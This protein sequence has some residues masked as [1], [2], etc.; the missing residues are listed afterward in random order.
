[1]QII[2]V[3]GWKNCG[4]TTLATRLITALS[5]RGLRVSSI[6]HAHH[7][8]DV[9]QPGTDSYR[10]RQ[11]GAGE[12]ILASANRVA[13]MQEL[14]DA[15]EP[16][17]DELVARLSP[18][19]WVVVEGYKAG[20]H[21]KIEAYRS[22]C[23]HRPLY[24]NDPAVVAVASDHATDYAGQTFDLDDIEAMVGWLLTRDPR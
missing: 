20:S 24:L 10:H 22:L 13:L 23:S 4:K 17:L 12:V 2:G 19:D 14:G 1:M 18:C 16:D 3:V 6:K 7:A 5:E 21:A 8:V 9:D 11:A 15:P